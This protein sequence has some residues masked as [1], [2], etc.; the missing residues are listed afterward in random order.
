M[1]LKLN[2]VQHALRSTGTNRTLAPRTAYEAP[3]LRAMGDIRLVTLGSSPGATESS[4]GSVSRK[5]AGT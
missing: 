4:G 1:E 3:Q 5:P 2:P